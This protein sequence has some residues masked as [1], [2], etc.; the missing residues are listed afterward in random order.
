ML[1]FRT[2]GKFSYG[3]LISIYDSR[4]F[5]R[6]FSA[7]FHSSSAL[8][9]RK[10]KSKLSGYF[11]RLNMATKRSRISLLSLLTFFTLGPYSENHTQLCF[12]VLFYYC[13]IC[14]LSPKPSFERGKWSTKSHIHLYILCTTLFTCE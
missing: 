9:V 12:K 3:L 2:K 4:Y 10:K 11:T 14:L 5:A 13:G 7:P 1:L 6:V 8:H